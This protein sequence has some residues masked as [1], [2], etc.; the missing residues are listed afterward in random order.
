LC[1]GLSFK[2]KRIGGGGPRKALPQNY[3]SKEASRTRRNRDSSA[4]PGASSEGI[5]KEVRR[6]DQQAIK[7]LEKK[8]RETE[9]ASLSAI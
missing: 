3:F 9:K 1:R 7:G 2:Q 5:F 8:D 4:K 6:D